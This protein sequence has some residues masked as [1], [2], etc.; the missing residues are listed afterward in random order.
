MAADPV[1]IVAPVTGVMVP[2]EEVPDPV[3]AKK[4]V[5]D[6][7]SVYPLTGVLRAPVAGEVVHIHDAHHAVTVRSA[8][9]L[10][11]LM[12]I[13]LD[14]VQMGGDGFDVRVS[15]GQRVAVGDELVR[16]D[17]TAVTERAASVLTQVVVA[18]GEL[19]A[20]IDP[21]I[22]MV[23]GGEDIAARV[24]LADTAAAAAP[25]TGSGAVESSS[26][27]GATKAG[28]IAAGA[29]AAGAALAGAVASSGSSSSDTATSDEIVIP[30][31]AGLHA[32]PAATLV[33]L[34]KEYASEIELRAGDQTGNVKSI[35]SIMA[36]GLARGTAVTLTATGPDAGTAVEELSAAIR[37]GLGEEIPTGAP[38]AA[39]TPAPAPATTPAPVTPAVDD[40]PTLLRGVSASPGVGVGPVVL[41]RAREF[42]VVEYADNPAHEHW[43]LDEAFRTARAE[44]DRLAGELADQP[45]KAAIFGAHAEILDDPELQSMAHAGADANKTA[46]FAWK[47]AYTQYADRLAA[48]DNEVLA[49]RATDVR[50][51]GTRVLETLTGAQR[52][53]RQL[54]ENA[55][56]V[57]ADL[58]P[59][60]TAQLDRSKV[61][62][63]A[64]VTGG[65]SSHV[66]IIAR[67]LDIPAVAGVDPRVL[68]LAEGDLV[69][70]DG[71]AGTVR[72]Q[73]SEAEV[74]QIR[75]RQ[76][77]MASRREADLA[78]A[79]EDALTTD[80]H[81][82]E[83]V[84][85][86]GNAADAA[87]ATSMGGEGVGLLRSEFA[88]LDRAEAPTEDEQAGLYADV[89]RALKPGQRL[90]IRTLDVGGDK[91]LPY[92]PMPAEENPF[93]GVRGVRIGL[94]QPE[95]LATQCRAIL[96]AADA[97][98]NLNVMFPMIATL[99]DFRRA[100]AIFDE[101]AQALGVA[102]VPLGIMVEVPSVAVMARQFAREA[103]FFS[104][105]T[106]DLTSYALAMD[107]G[108]ARLAS[109]VD[110][111]NPAVLALIGQAAQAAHDEGKWI[112]VCGG[113]ASDIQAVPFLLGLGVDELSCSVPAIPGVKAAVRS[114]SMDHCR[115]LAARALAAG[116]AAEVRALNPIDEA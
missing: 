29:V 101:Q 38:A 35:M 106:N 80:G 83:V 98:A 5:G 14:T 108:H 34:A 91:P 115:E 92:L 102:R 109:Q 96:R 79:H 70:L 9:G 43:R 52:E 20:S 24:T 88:F 15:T 107:R 19:V 16:F 53:Q 114:L 99:D 45:D 23:T 81:R 44:L 6:G 4:M 37:S 25:V 50:D 26:T 94:E 87:E 89:A 40:D 103:D 71:S 78:R 66:A 85:N 33:N 63:F 8:E 31:P 36:L 41:I 60:D 47:S 7:F 110:P 59:S 27:G 57:A 73:V 100:K 65:A 42:D 111:C 2:I 86:V 68:D 28:L 3:F 22:G 75:E 69:I 13:G 67:S 51:V 72:T 17:L 77:R 93:L 116:T 104:V 64:T 76:S 62:G 30:N 1:E 48:L 11:I 61:A 21:V 56:L 12:H 84:A 74:A 82:V 112:G 10:E 105:G 97:G 39:A 95:I 90:V 46:E 55:I 32:R 58:T 49:G 54:P 113:M 18:N